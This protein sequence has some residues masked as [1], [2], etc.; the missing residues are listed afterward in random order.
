MTTTQP[1]PR[2]VHD[3]EEAEDLGRVA[4]RM[5]WGKAVELCDPHEWTP[6]ARK[7]W[8]ALLEVIHE[9]PYHPGGI[10]D[11]MD[12]DRRKACARRF[13][14]A[15]EQGKHEKQAETRRRAA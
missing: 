12:D 6:E 13:D 8:T 11:D 10:A 3:L 5:W 15:F 2:F 14:I 9:N 4:G 1:T 7:K